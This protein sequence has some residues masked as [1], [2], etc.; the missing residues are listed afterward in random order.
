MYKESSVSDNFC[1]P[2]QF[3]FCVF[4]FN[5]ILYILLW[6][7]LKYIC[8]SVFSIYLYSV[9]QATVL[10]VKRFSNAVDQAVGTGLKEI[11]I[12]KGLTTDNKDGRITFFTIKIAFFLL[13]HR[14]FDNK[15]CEN[16]KSWKKC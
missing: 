8:G 16:A 13:K 10:E 12:E 14:K 11:C 2:N 7:L 15:S 3:S 6:L 4:V 9:I 1:I 5:I